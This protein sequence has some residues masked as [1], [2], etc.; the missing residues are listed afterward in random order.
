MKINKIIFKKIIFNNLDYKN[1]NK[2]IIKKGLFV[3]PAGPALASI[4]QSKKYYDSIK[5]ADFV[6]F[7]SGFF[8]LL[9]KVFKN[10]N[11]NK[12]SGFKFLNLFFDYLKKN[13][14]KKVFCIDPN[15][16]FSNSN[17]LFLKNLG[18]HNI[19]NYLA[20]KYDIKNLSDKNLLKQLKKIKPDFILT[21]IGGG[22]QEILGLYLKENLKIKTT[23]LCTGGAIS[24]FTKDQAP[25]N[26]FIDEVYLGW[27]VRLMFNPIVFFCRLTYGLKLIPMVIF[28][29]IKV[30]K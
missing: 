30:I 24:F 6:F 28:N 3:F 8:V 2:Y 5:K 16:E 18:L 1:F 23:I 17:K 14:N 4:E 15:I 7:D 21:N 26:T 29:K 10:I 12:F 9:L 25:I 19:H 11:V 22:K 13:K 27:F 20:P